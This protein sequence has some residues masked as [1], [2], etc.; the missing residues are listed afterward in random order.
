MADK[1]KESGSLVDEIK[2]APSASEIQA[3]S[4][5]AASEATKPS[6][7]PKEAPVVVAAPVVDSTAAANIEAQKK[8][9]EKAARKAE[10]EEARK[11][12]KIEKKAKKAAEFQAKIEQ[13]PKDYRPVTIGVFFWCGLLCALPVIGVIFTILF[14]LIPR[15][16]NFKNFARALLAWYVIALIVF[17]IFAVIATFVMGQSI[18]D[19]IWPFEKFF[20]D[21]ASALGF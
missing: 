9:A 20:S 2:N 6:E 1:E 15:N 13:C 12:A 8:A 21:M 7:T 14:S 11:Q 18:T 17:L 3:A 19:F 16:K 5:L 10:K 4:P